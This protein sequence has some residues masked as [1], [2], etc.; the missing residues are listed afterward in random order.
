M[1]PSA[2]TDNVAAP[3]LPSRPSFVFPP[4]NPDPS[5][6]PPVNPQQPFVGFPP[7]MNPNQPPPPSSNNPPPTMAG[8]PPGMN[9]NQPPP[10]S[11]NNPPP[12]M[13]GFPPGL[14]FNQ[15]PPPSSNN[16]PS[17]P[18]PPQNNPQQPFTGFPP[19]LNSQPTNVQ[20]NDP[21]N[22]HQGI[23]SG[24]SSSYRSQSNNQDDNVSRLELDYPIENVLIDA[25]IPSAVAVKIN[26]A[27][28]QDRLG[29]AYHIHRYTFEPSGPQH[30]SYN[31]QRQTGNSLHGGT[32]HIREL[33]NDHQNPLFNDVP[34]SSRSN[35]HSRRR[36][37]YQSETALDQYI[38]Q[39]LHTPGSTVI[40][41]RN[42][43][44]LQHILNQRLVPTQAYP[45]QPA[46]TPFQS[47]IDA[48]NGPVF[49]YTARA[50]Q[51]DPMR[52]Y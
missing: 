3:D 41:A 10:S 20:T 43:N 29:N 14:N 39:L 42:Y 2:N 16:Q 4:Q 32:R 13:T 19:G 31:N 1:S 5:S 40:E 46:I 27:V 36:H 7:G 23:V 11:S 9:L 26:D 33:H 38:D 18:P 6:R 44:D 51:H 15:P 21:I 17:A 45:T 34:Y 37:H 48:F 24:R 52:N 25:N 49:Y 50:L 47:N 28:E 30:L 35:K 8:F 12:K 22:P